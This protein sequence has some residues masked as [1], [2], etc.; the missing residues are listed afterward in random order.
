VFTTALVEGLETGEA[1]RGQDGQVGLD[2]LNE[3]VCDKVRGSQ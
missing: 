2:E 1:G 3:Y